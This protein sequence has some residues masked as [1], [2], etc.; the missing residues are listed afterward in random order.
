MYAKSMVANAPLLSEAAIRWEFVSPRSR[1]PSGT[2]PVLAIWPPDSKVLEL[3][4]RMALNSSLCVICGHYDI[5]P[6]IRKANAVC[7][8]EGYET[9]LTEPALPPEVIS[10][11]D[12]M[13]SFDAHNGFLG[14]GGKEDAIRRLQSIA[15]S[16]DRPTPDA[17]EDYLSSRGETSAKGAR[18]ASRWYEEV[19][20]G[21][22]H[23]DYRARII[24]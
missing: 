18:R 8:V 13:L 5:S 9:G 16:P 3:A 2:G 19:L 15:R 14:A 6:W 10:S 22:R 7:L 1:R 20:A 21:K 4:E 12:A 11:L 17:I 23:R 24:P